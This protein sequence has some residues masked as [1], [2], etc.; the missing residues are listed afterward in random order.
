MSVASQTSPWPLRATLG[1]GVL[2]LL[3]LT[4]AWAE[5]LSPGTEARIL[6]MLATVGCVGFA[7]LA[8]PFALPLRRRANSEASW[9]ALFAHVCFWGGAAM[10][11]TLR[12]ALLDGPSEEATFFLLLSAL[13]LA[14]AVWIHRWR[15]RKPWPGARVAFAFLPGWILL[16]FLA[17]G[18][19]L[20]EDWP[21]SAT[22]W[23]FAAGVVWLTVRRLSEA[24][25]P[26]GGAPA[27]PLPAE[28]APPEAPGT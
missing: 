18:G 16:E 13:P 14:G 12:Y 5:G 3:S 9:G 25:V 27:A 26:S 22:C 8:L 19:S 23:A 7:L 17:R 2:S 4:P 6:V 11:L 10:L 20:L 24:T 21:Q 1:G 15:G 28:S